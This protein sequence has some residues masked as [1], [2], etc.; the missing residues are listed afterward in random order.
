MMYKQI[1]D[2]FLQ[3]V[4]LSFCMSFM[5]GID[6]LLLLTKIVWPLQ[7]LEST[8]ALLFLVGVNGFMLAW[9][10]LN[11]NGELGERILS[12]P[13]PS[14]LTSPHDGHFPPPEYWTLLV[15]DT[16]FFRAT[17]SE[18]FT[19]IRILSS[20]APDFWIE[21]AI[22]LTRLLLTTSNPTGCVRAL[23]FNLIKNK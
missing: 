5:S 7:T 20:K 14:H 4:Y 16:R 19:C 13:A 22:P 12:K 11:W 23:V 17:Y 21:T 8:V 1:L 6:M 2:I 18:P 15:G 3:K 10:W 9:S